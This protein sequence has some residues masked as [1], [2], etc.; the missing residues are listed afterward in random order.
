MILSK[1]CATLFEEAVENLAFGA[2][3]LE[4]FSMRRLA[5]AIAQQF[6]S[7]DGIFAGAGAGKAG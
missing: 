4:G 1:G 2:I 3:P 6:W 7:I 5:N